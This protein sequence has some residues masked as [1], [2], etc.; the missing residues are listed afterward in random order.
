M[1]HSRESRH[2]ASSPHELDL[3]QA[4]ATAS[5][6]TPR[7]CVPRDRDSFRAFTS[8]RLRVICGGGKG[9]GL[10]TG[11]VPALSIASTA[12]LFCH[13]AG[14]VA[15]I[16]GGFLLGLQQNRPFGPFG[17]KE[18]L[19]FFGFALSL[20]GKLSGTHGLFGQFGLTRQL[21]GFAL[22][23]ADQTHLVHSHPGGVPPGDFGVFG[24]GAK[25][26]QHRPLGGGGG[27]LALLAVRVLEAAHSFSGS[28]RPGAEWFRPSGSRH[29]EVSV[30]METSF[31]LTL[32]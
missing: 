27:T 3:A 16:P 31:F 6:T 4:P 24:C 26:L 14:R 19:F 17:G 29:V 2:H 5:P 8:P 30:V 1:G 32:F 10:L 7:R 21:G 9:W 22:S 11:P 13:F 15:G 12:F 18:S 23:H 25:L 28:S 20:R